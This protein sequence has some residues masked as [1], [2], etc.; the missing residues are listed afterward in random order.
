MDNPYPQAKKARPQLK[1][2]L[3]GQPSRSN[4]FDQGAGHLIPEM[5]GGSQPQSPF[6][7]VLV[8]LVRGLRKLLLRQIPTHHN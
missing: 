7:K 8:E 2:C 6:G 1:G 4:R 5:A 3:P